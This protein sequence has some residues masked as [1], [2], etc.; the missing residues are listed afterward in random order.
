MKEIIKFLKML[1]KTYNTVENYNDNINVCCNIQ[2]KKWNYED[3]AKQVLFQQ[4]HIDGIFLSIVDNT[5]A[6]RNLSPDNIEYDAVLVKAGDKRYNLYTKKSAFTPIMLCHE[7]KHLEQYQQ[8]KLELMSNKGYKWLGKEYPPD[9]PYNDRP[10][11]K[12]AFGI[13]NKLWRTYK[14]SK[15][16]K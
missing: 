12:E 14:Q 2:S 7:L 5:A 11:E 9:Y 16:N 3:I 13:Q 10:W 4:L 8:N 1:F 6:L 15:K